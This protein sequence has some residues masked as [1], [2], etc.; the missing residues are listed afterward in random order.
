MKK[1]LIIILLLLILTGAVVFRMYRKNSRFDDA[2][3][4][5]NEA[6]SED[7]GGLTTSGLAG[8]SSRYA[9]IADKEEIRADNFVSNTYAT[10]MVNNDTKECIVAHNVHER[11]YPASMT[12][13]LTGIV[14]CDAVEAGEISMDEV[15]EL[16]HNIALG[17][18]YAVQSDLS[19]GCKITVR[20]LLTALMLSSYN[21]YAVILGERISGSVEQFVERMNAKARE[22]GATCTHCSNPHGLDAL[23]HYTTAYDLYLIVNKAGEYE[24]LNNIDLYSDYTYTW[25][26][27]SG[28]VW[29]DTATATNHFITDSSTLPSNITIGTWKTGTT[30]GA[31][32]CLTMEVTI[33]EVSYTM[34]VQDKISKD[35][36]YD[37]YSV[38]FNMAR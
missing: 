14:V 5:N 18:I 26:D 3:S 27:A 33:N 21:D 16:D 36:L 20:N 8:F 29:E 10:L 19:A 1:G 7:L 24:I 35:D 4:E 22:I 2:Y 13:L 15:I 9:V 6:I 34:L 30:G 28:N 31:G 23:D 12:K 38:L 17:N 32:N 37:T 11:I 25:E